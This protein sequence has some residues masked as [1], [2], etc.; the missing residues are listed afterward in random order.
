[1]PRTNRVAVGRIVYHVP[2]RSNGRVQILNNKE[3]GL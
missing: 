3:K 2:N 1:M